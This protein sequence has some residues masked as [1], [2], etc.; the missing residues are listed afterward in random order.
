MCNLDGVIC[1]WK[2]W[3]PLG[4]RKDILE[5]PSQMK[6]FKCMPGVYRGEARFLYMKVTSFENEDKFCGH[7]VQFFVQDSLF[8]LKTETV[9]TSLCK[10]GLKCKETKSLPSRWLIPE[11]FWNIK[12][13]LDEFCM[14]QHIP[15]KGIEGKKKT[16][17]KKT[18][19]LE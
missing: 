6:L 3:G 17:K 18:N 4:F 9:F 14:R 1:R 7:K 11:S 5:N 13:T 2:F 12:W 19:G 8:V 16:K 15:N 10:Y